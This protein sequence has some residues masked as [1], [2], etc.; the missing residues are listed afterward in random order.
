MPLLSLELAMIR[1]RGAGLLSVCTFTLAIVALSY[2]PAAH[3]WTAAPT[4]FEAII[5]TAPTSGDRVLPPVLVLDQKALQDRQAQLLSG[6]LRGIPGVSIRPN[7]RGESVVRIRGSE[8]RQ[9]AVFL[10][11][12]PLNVP[13]DG[14]VDL[15][16]LPAQLISKIKVTKG[17]VPIEYGANAVAGAVDL[18]TWR[19]GDAREAKLDAGNL[20]QRGISGLGQFSHATADGLMQTTLA[21]NILVRDALAVADRQSLQFGQPDDD[22]RTNTDLDSRSVF[23]AVGWTGPAWS[24]RAS[25]LHADV[26]RG[27]APEAHIDPAVATPRYWRYP[28]WR[29]TQASL[30]SEGKL[31]DEATI[32]GV[33]WQ[34]WFDQTIEAYR[35]S[36]YERLQ[37]REDGQDRSFGGR[38][39]LTHPLGPLAV[40]WSASAQ[41][42]T[43]SQVD[44]RFPAGTPGPELDY[45]QRL[46]SLGVEAD[47]PLNESIRTTFGIGLD[48]ASTP[49][50]GDKPAQGDQSASAFSAA[51]AWAINRQ[52]TMTLSG[53]QRTRFPSA[54]ELFGE[55]LG[56]FL[57]N[58]DL[59]P[60]R[61]SLFD[62]EISW[63]QQG[64]FV[65]INPFWQHSQDTL[66]QRVV[67]VN[68]KSL[69]QRFNL[70]GSRSWGVDVYAGFPI[71]PSVT[72]E[73]GGSWLRT[74]VEVSPE[75]SLRRLP[76]R[77]GHDAFAA[78][79]W[80]S[81]GKLDVRAEVRDVGAAFDIG[82][83]GEAVALPGGTEFGFRL[84][85]PLP[86][87]QALPPAR[88]I[89]SLDNAFNASIEPQLGLPA[90]G[91]T[92]R[93]GIEFGDFL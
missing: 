79:D 70:P 5:V 83:D 29:L 75:F 9:A 43:H 26:E 52:W 93:V 76:Q 41:A 87:T 88:L 28:D 77:P 61:V 45:E 32:R 30:V 72:A 73:F 39:T 31:G 92:Y 1:K 36:S 74:S 85:H 57:I 60:E 14:R 23:A 22:A 81:W 24:W 65:S 21:A 18:Q 86:Q 50:T 3:A 8:E 69:R 63:R 91:R 4:A 34:Q 53:G 89:F 33:F 38:T 17:A 13:W 56:R 27:I 6:A 64:R 46:G 68:G 12:A 90:P 42:S 40:R 62:L 47:W 44:T 80:Q 19:D 54:R 48:A 84:S 78:L 25:I 10:D 11:G 59:L 66:S 7:S 55:A 37:S 82:P 16:V 51:A 2:A 35:D 49:Q 71:S 67:R 58:P 15:G 20:G